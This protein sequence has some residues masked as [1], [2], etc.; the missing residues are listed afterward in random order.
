MI[1]GHGLHMVMKWLLL[2]LALISVT[3]CHDSVQTEQ[4]KAS[5]PPDGWAGTDAYSG[6]AG[7]TAGATPGAV[8]YRLGLSDKGPGEGTLVSRGYHTDGTRRCGITAT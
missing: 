7:E 3:A 1:V 4:P 6:P 5:D 2:I 8:G